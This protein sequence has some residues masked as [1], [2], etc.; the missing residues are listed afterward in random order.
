MTEHDETNELRERLHQ[1]ADRTPPSSDLAGGSITRARRI[2]RRRTVIAAVTAV[3]IAGGGVVGATTL[4]GWSGG[5]APVAGVTATPT[6]PPPTPTSTT[7]PSDPAP[8]T[9]SAPPTS[10]GPTE[11]TSGSQD[12]EAPPPPATTRQPTADGPASS[13][14]APPSNEQRAPACTAD[15]TTIKVLAKQAAAGHVEY[16]ITLTNTSDHDCTVQGFPGVS[17]VGGDDGTQ[18]GAPADR[19]REHGPAE[20]VTVPPGG[21]ASASLWVARA[22]NYGEKCDAT[23]ARGFRIYLPEERA[24]QFAPIE[25]RGCQNPDVHLMQI[26]PFGAG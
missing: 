25:V 14:S 22:D 19:D 1:Q 15:G 21:L 3:V 24:A 5:D 13:N 10:P 16:V 2:R 20:L 8:S 26:R 18:I 9:S 23:D 11:E 7:E 6:V 4:R 12:T 17:M